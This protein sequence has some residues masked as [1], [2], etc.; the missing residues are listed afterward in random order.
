MAVIRLLIAYDGTDFR[1]WARQPGQRTVQGVIEGVL[2]RMLRE[3]PR[4]SVAGR[5]DAGVHAEGQVASFPAPDCADPVRIQRALNGGLGPEVAVLEARWVPASFDARRC[6]TGR[7]YRYTIDMGPVPSP[8]TARYAWHHP[9]GLAVA[10]MRAAARLLEGEHDF[11][12]FCRAPQLPAT[13]TVRTLRRLSVATKEDRLTIR[14][15]ADGFL[16]QMVRSLVGTLLRVGEGKMEPDT[17][18]AVLAARDRSEAGPL[19]P[20][21]GLTLVRVVY[22]RP[23]RRVDTGERDSESNE[24]S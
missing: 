22:G 20:P 23:R 1:G 18:P 12:S 5:T 19:A 8:F 15:A 9:G 11:A 3:A 2:A 7:E 16:H 4:L 13:G 24:Q 14:A 10:S 17:M 21:H 6:A